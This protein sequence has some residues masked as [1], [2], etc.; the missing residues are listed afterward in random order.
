MISFSNID[1]VFSAMS[2]RHLHRLLERPC[3]HTFAFL[4]QLSSKNDLPPWFTV[5]EPYERPPDAMEGL[6]TEASRYRKDFERMALK[7]IFDKEIKLF[8]IAR[9]I[10]MPKSMDLSDQ[11]KLHFMNKSI[12][13]H[14]PLYVTSLTLSKKW[15]T[16]SKDFQAEVLD[17]LAYGRVMVDED[18]EHEGSSIEVLIYDH[19]LQ[20]APHSGSSDNVTYKAECDASYYKKSKTATAAS[21][22]WKCGNMIDGQISWGHS[23]CNSVH[24]EVVSH[25]NVLTRGKEL[26][27]NIEKIDI[28]TDLDENHEIMCGA[29]ELPSCDYSNVYVACIRVAKQYKVCKVRWQPREMLGLVNDMAKADYSE[30]INLPQILQGKASYIWGAPFLRIHKSKKEVVDKLGMY[31][32]C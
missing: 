8:L 29:K 6:L 20:F 16:L 13:G 31:I 9:C 24:A 32:W 15:V 19:G 28:V 12:I 11:K 26:D 23:C 27:Y 1:L 21:I 14:F 7:D 5:P 22:I 17:S 25:C 3:H 30:T 4:R 10:W 2:L 18:R